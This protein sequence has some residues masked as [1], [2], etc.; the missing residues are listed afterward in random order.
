FARSWGSAQSRI[1]LFSLD[2]P[3]AL[4]SLQTNANPDSYPELSDDGQIFAYISDSESDSIYESRAHYSVLTGSSYAQSQAIADPTDF[5]GYGD[6]NV[7]IAGDTSFAAAA[8]VRLASDLPGKDEGDTV[9]VEEQNL[10]M[11]GA[12][13]VASVYEN[14]AW[15][16]SRLT[17]NGTP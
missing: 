2:T 3:S 5:T 1:A 10:L 12:E 17:A 7:D 8:F 11:N 13:I 6:S 14:G 16:S 9:S 15:T 4:K